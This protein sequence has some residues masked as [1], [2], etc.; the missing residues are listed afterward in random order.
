MPESNLYQEQYEGAEYYW[1]KEPSQSCRDLLNL[2]QSP[3]DRPLSLLDIGCGEGRNAVHFARHGFLVTAIDRSSAGLEKT[4]RLAQEC[5]VTVTTIEA[6]INLWTPDRSFDVLFSSG[7]LHYLPPEIRTAKFHEY[8]EATV[9]GRINAFSVLIEKPFIP[10]SP[11]AQPG[12]RLFRSG[13]LMAHYWDWEMLASS[14]E[15]FD[16]RSGGIP[17]RHAVN[18]IIARRPAGWKA[19][20][21]HEPRQSI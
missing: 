1:G 4:A 9:A 21:G 8:R 11:D 17:H 12:V 6:D 19:H 13:E 20:S 16:C 10:P 14:E 7:T 18:R 2:V 3:P 15:I 5:G